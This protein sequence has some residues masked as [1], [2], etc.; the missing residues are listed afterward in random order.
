[1]ETRRTL[2]PKIQEYIRLPQRLPP[3]KL[4]QMAVQGPGK[5]YYSCDCVVLREGLANLRSQLP[6]S[7]VQSK[8]AWLPW[9]SDKGDQGGRHVEKSYSSPSGGEGLAIMH[10]GF[11]L[12]MDCIVGLSQKPREGPQPLAGHFGLPYLSTVG[13]NSAVNWQCQAHPP[14]IHSCCP[15]TDTRYDHCRHVDSGS[16]QPAVHC[17]L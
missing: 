17:R 10:V 1:V 15:I 14:H 2:P 4:Q 16:T 13:H 12:G 8:A 9:G 5:F 6:C 3:A 7:L 11:L